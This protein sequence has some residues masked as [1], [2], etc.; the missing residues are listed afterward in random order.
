MPYVKKTPRYKDGKIIRYDYYLAEDI[1]TN[2]GRTTRILNRLS[3]EE[4]LNRIKNVPITE[5]E[6]QKTE[7]SLDTQ[8]LKVLI[9]VFAKARLKVEL[10]LEYQERIKE[11]AKDVI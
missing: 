1:T 2:G 11:L 6:E 5:H 8:I 10:S 7:H 9:P 3:E 4:A